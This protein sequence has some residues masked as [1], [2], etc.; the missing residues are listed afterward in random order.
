MPDDKTQV[1]KPDRD[2]INVGE[3]YELRGWAKSLGVTPQRLIDV[4]AKVGPMA[5]DVRRELSKS[6]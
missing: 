1:G 2:R 4:V 5:D 3:E 6:E